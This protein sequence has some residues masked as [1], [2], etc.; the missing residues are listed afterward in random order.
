MNKINRETFF[1]EVKKELFKE[2]FRG[3]KGQKQ[4]EGLDLLITEWEARP[5]INLQQ[6]AYILATVYH[7]TAFTMQP[8]KEMGGTKYLKAKPYWPYYGRGYVQLTWEQNYK[9][10]SEKLGYDFINKPNDVMLPRHAVKILFDGME[11]GWFTNVKLSQK[12]DNVDD[13]DEEEIKEYKSARTIVNGTDRD[14]QIAQYAI[15]FERSLYRSWIVNI[16]PIEKDIP[17]TLGPAAAGAGGAGMFTDGVIAVGESVGNNQGL[18]ASGDW[19]KVIVGLII[20]SG[21]L[22][23]LFARWDAAG[24]P[25]FWQRS[26]Q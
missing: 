10:A 20:I 21:S 22:Y 17:S 8:I 11:Q 14:L 15:H 24:R 13:P 4:I 26:R 23:A 12:I 5:E 16:E 19:W 9:K 25:K 18:F 3:Q 6:F 1:A 2:R 7:E